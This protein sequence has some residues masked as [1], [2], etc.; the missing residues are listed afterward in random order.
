MFFKQ[1][2]FP[3]YFDES[4]SY[5]LLILVVR[6]FFGV[7]LISHGYDKLLAYGSTTEYFVDPLSVGSTLSFWMVIFAEIV[8]AFALIFGLLQRIVLIPIIISMVVAFFIIHE[9]DPFAAKELAFIY[10]IVFIILY[11]TGPGKYSF[12]SIIGNY[13]LQKEFERS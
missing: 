6:I 3:T 10:L 2:L 13:M 4:R 12:D 8:C 1:F 5:S 7:L 11:I 9:G